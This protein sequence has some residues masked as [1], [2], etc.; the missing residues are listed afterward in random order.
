[1]AKANL[2]NELQSCVFAESRHRLRDPKHAAHDIMTRI[3]Q[4]PK[5]RQSLHRLLNLRL[6]TRLDHR[7]D[8]HW[9]RRVDDAEDILAR[10][11]AEAGKRRLQVVDRLTHVAFSGE[12]ERSYS[13]I[14][15]LHVLC[16]AHLHQSRN[17][18]RICEAGVAEDSAT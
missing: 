6:P 12:N 18:L 13:V 10:H 15:V 8:F 7:L 5:F 17:N 1:M 16:F 4:I 11:E 2:P 14:R 3:P 9:V